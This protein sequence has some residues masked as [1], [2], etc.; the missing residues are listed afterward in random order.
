MLHGYY[1][2]CMQRLALELQ[3]LGPGKPCQTL[4]ISCPFFS[5][6]CKSG[7]DRRRSMQEPSP[8]DT[9]HLY[10][11]FPPSPLLSMTKSFLLLF[12]LHLVVILFF[13][14]PSGSVSS[15]PFHPNL[16]FLF[17]IPFFLQFCLSSLPTPL[18]ASLS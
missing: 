13:L 16:C 7:R 10:C 8:Q 3:C 11:P 4:R 6:L 12:I 15:S 18:R 5:A 2:T 14:S 1:T 9:F 17:F